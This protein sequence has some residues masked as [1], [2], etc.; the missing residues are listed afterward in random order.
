MPEDLSAVKSAS[1]KKMTQDAKYWALLGMELMDL[2]KG[3]AKVKLK[4]SEKLTHP[5]GMAHGGAVFSPADSAIAMA[6][7]TL[8]DTN[9]IYTTVE[10]KINY[11][12]PF[13]KGEITAEASIIHKGKNIAI[14]DVS[15]INE[16]GH[17]IARGLATYMILTRRNK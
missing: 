17:L 4:F 16:R 15:V 7:A 14:G 8:V 3:W 5:M 2:K 6:L 13:Q 10:M 11:L 9:E 12:K 1:I